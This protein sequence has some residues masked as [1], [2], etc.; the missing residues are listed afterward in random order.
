MLDATQ[1]E[2]VV[3]DRYRFRGFH[4]CDAWCA[5]EIL[6][7]EDGRTGGDRDRGEGHR[8]HFSPP[9]A[10]RGIIA[11]PMAASSAGRRVDLTV[12]DRLRL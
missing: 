12:A 9:S 8:L 3:V 11:L 7:A 6:R 2:R 4:G 5:L 10:R 1:Y